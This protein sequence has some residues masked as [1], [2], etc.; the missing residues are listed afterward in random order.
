[1]RSRTSTAGLPPIPVNARRF[2]ATCHPHHRAGRLPHATRPRR[3]HLIKVKTYLTNQACGG[4]LVLWPKTQWNARNTGRKKD[5]RA[6]SAVLQLL[7]GNPGRLEN[8]ILGALSR[9]VGRK[10]GARS[11]VAAAIERVTF[12]SMRLPRGP[13]P[14][15]RSFLASFC[16]QEFGFRHGKHLAECH[17]QAFGGRTAFGQVD[18]RG[19]SHFAFFSGNVFTVTVF[20]MFRSDFSTVDP[21]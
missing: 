9:S 6:H 3:L 21:C 7:L 10:A 5:H 2:F 12:A 18:G 16:F 19:C 20:E 11:R 4:S 17:V 13:L 1:M 14:V 8:Y 15:A